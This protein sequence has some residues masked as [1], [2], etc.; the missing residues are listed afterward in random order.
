MDI[1]VVDDEPLARQR[2]ARIVESLGHE[3]VAIAEN[4]S[5][6]FDAVTEHDPTLV[7]LD[8]EMPGD[9]GLK[10]AAKISALDNPPAIIFCTAYDQ[11]AL[12]AFDTLAVGYLL[13]PVKREQLAHALIK[14]QTVTKAQMSAIAPKV[15][16]S[17]RRKHI[18]AKSHKGME[19]IPLENV[20]FFMAD[21]KYVTVF[22]TE[23]KVLIDET[24]K[25]LETELGDSFVRV[26]R[27]ALVSLSHIQGLDRDMNGH[28]AVVLHDIDEKPLVSRRYAG[29]IKDLLKRL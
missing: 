3:V 18:T 1:I 25:E 5:E 28:Y 29:K 10:A 22:H 21:Q 7:L 4:A 2:L 27:N 9:N 20:R 11:Y 12:D 23:G 26:H 8:I 16:V 15:E 6:A 13:K 19:L 14:A 24:L 17:D